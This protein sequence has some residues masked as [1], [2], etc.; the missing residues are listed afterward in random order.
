MEFLSRTENLI[1][2]EKALQIINE[3]RL[4][5]YDLDNTALNICKT[6]LI[7]KYGKSKKFARQILY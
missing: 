3:G 6:I 7:K 1:G 5:L 4:Y 2:K